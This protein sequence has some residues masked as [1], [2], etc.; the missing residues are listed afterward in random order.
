MRHEVRRWLSL[1]LRRNLKPLATTLQVENGDYSAPLLRFEGQRCRKS[2]R[3][4]MSLREWISCASMRRFNTFNHLLREGAIYESSEFDVRRSNSHFKLTDVPV[5]VDGSSTLDSIKAKKAMAP[6]KLGELGVVDP[7]RDKSNCIAT[8]I[9]SASGRTKWFEIEILQDT[10][11]TLITSLKTEW[12]SLIFCYQVTNGEAW[13]LPE[14]A[15]ETLSLLKNTEVGYEKPDSP[16]FKCAVVQI[17]VEANR[18]VHVG[19]DE[20]LIK[21]VQTSSVLIAGA[22]QIPFQV[23]GQRCA[24]IFRHTRSDLGFRTLTIKELSPMWF[25]SG[26]MEVVVEQH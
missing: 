18:A 25:S 26:P 24:D 1:G 19:D 5:S 10:V 15:Y 4:L 14:G 8:K 11:L 21:A 22:A 6:D 23:M 9:K 17:N 3:N 7:K 16:I 20:E 2:L 13:H 12:R